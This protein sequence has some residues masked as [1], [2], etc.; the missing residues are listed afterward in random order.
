[1]EP[2]RHV[3]KVDIPCSTYAYPDSGGFRWPARKSDDCWEPS[4]EATSYH[5]T[6]PAVRMGAL[7]AIPDPLPPWIT[8]D[9]LYT[10]IGRKLFEA[11][12]SYGA[13][14]ADN[15][16]WDCYYFCAE[17]GVH[18]EAE[19]YYG[20]SINTMLDTPYRQD[21]N[22][23][24]QWLHVVDNNIPESI[25]GPGDRIARQIVELVEEGQGD[26]SWVSPDRPRLSITKATA[27]RITF[28]IQITEPCKG[29]LKVYGVDGRVAAT[30]FTGRF[31]SGQTDV[32]WDLRAHGH[33]IASG[34]YFAML[35]TNRGTSTRRFIAVR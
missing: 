26:S 13:Y 12:R 3:L 18:A 6:N 7:L 9:S 28:M 25:G 32:A 17:Y 27:D 34:V 8:P 30:I 16:G 1:T 4:C 35:R 11:L 31:A 21:V 29:D 33:K 2:I 10:H 20:H 5:G 19:A 14:V 15:S 23:L 22:R 24:F